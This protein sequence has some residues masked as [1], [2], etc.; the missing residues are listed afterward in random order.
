M[1]THELAKE[2]M[3]LPDVPVCFEETNAAGEEYLKV[4]C[5]THVED[6]FLFMVGLLSKYSFTHLPLILLRTKP[7]S[8]P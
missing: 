3:N 4:I 1:T 7:C 6:F 2:L 5:R 8:M